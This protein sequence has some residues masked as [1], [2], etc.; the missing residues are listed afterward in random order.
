[1]TVE[2][3]LSLPNRKDKKLPNFQTLKIKNVRLENNRILRT[4]EFLEQ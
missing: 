2:A 3:I 4:I 1:M